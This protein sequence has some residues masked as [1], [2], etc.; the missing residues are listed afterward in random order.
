LS[1]F[2][3]IQLQTTPEDLSFLKSITASCKI[4]QI[5]HY[6]SRY[7]SIPFPI[8]QATGSLPETDWQLDFTQC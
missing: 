8:H 3:K 2:V 1:S 6:S 5:S 4:C 7:R